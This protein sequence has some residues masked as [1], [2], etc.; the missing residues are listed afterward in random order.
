MENELSYFCVISLQP[1]ERYFEIIRCFL[2]GEG[3]IGLPAS[4]NVS[5]LNPEPHGAATKHHQVVKKA[6]SACPQIL[7]TLTTY[8]RDQ[9]NLEE[10]V[11]EE[12]PCDLS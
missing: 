2:G 11:G 10:K 1:P 3:W 4:R 12:M 7:S 5:L 9:V 8:G 6:V